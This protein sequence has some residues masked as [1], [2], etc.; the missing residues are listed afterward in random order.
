MPVVLVKM[1]DVVHVLLEILHASLDVS[2]CKCLGD[3]GHRAWWQLETQ[4]LFSGIL[5]A[6]FSQ[7]K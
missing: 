7:C 4:D 3:T 5:W 6:R 2:H 1:T